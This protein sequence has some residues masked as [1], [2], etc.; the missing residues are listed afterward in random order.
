MD[1]QVD[2]EG[3][4]SEILR[5][6]QDALG[7]IEAGIRAVD[8]LDVARALDCHR[9]VGQHLLEVTKLQGQLWAQIKVEQEALAR[10]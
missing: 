1:M 10:D 2:I 7:L 6:Q 3:T 8:A 5:I 9:Q 4:L